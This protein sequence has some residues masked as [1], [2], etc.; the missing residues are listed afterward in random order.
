MWI[1][2]LCK[3]LTF[4]IIFISHTNQT[5]IHGRYNLDVLKKISTTNLDEDSSRPTSWTLW[6]GASI[7][8][9]I[10]LHIKKSDPKT[11]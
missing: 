8:L 7:I 10:S 6:R 3:G 4:H 1:Q 11:N 5:E 9:K 2:E